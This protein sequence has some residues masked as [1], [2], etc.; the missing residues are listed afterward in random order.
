MVIHAALARQESRGPHF[1]EDFPFTDN[2]NWLKHVVVT[3]TNG[4]VAIRLVPVRQKYAR[5]TP[6]ITDYLANP[7]A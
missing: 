6:G 2:T 4:Q 7:Y 5:P 3:R 1:R